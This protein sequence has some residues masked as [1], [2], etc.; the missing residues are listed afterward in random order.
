[1]TDMLNKT[2]YVSCVSEYDYNILKK[3][4]K[5]KE[6]VA[7]IKMKLDKDLESNIKLQA[8]VKAQQEAMN[9]LEDE[10][11]AQIEEYN[12]SIAG[13]EE[14]VKKYMNAKAEAEAIILSA[15]PIIPNTFWNDLESSIIGACICI[16]IGKLLFK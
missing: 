7:N 14:E 1:M 8:E 15:E 9:Q 13:Q 4:K 6:K 10:K 3:L 16:F 5:A 2:E 11:K 12:V